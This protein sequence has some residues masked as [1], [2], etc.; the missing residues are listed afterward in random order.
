MLREFRGIVNY[1]QI[2]IITRIVRRQSIPF[3]V[4]HQM[5]RDLSI[6]KVYDALAMWLDDEQGL[7]PYC[8]DALI[9]IGTALI[10][11]AENKSVER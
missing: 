4:L 3:E 1:E 11:Y 2:D 5:K 10:S 7:A 8:P 6:Y 9:E